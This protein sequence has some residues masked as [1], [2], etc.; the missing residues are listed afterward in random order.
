[1]NPHDTPITQLADQF[2]TDLKAGLSDAKAKQILGE[3]GP[4]E[5]EGKPPKTMM[6]RFLDQFKDAMIIILLIAAMISLVIAIRGH[7]PMEYFEP[8]LILLI[9]KIGRAHV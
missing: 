9:V 3:V 5:L 1:M 6:Q 7:D 2:K 4:N 8:G